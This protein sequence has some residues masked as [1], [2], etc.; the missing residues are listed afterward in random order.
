RCTIKSGSIQCWG[1]YRQRSLI[2]SVAE[3]HAETTNRL[4]AVSILGFTTLIRWDGILQEPEKSCNFY[5]CL[6]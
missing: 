6:L 3:G 5:N 2:G 1:I 4:T